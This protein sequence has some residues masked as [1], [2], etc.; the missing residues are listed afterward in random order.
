VSGTLEHDEVDHL[1]ETDF[2]LVQRMALGE[3]DA[4]ARFHSRHGA[5]AFAVARR[6][7]DDLE[8]AEEAVQDA[9][10]AVWRHAAVFRRSAASPRTWLISIVRNRCIDEL[11]RRRGLA[12]L[13]LDDVQPIAIEN[14][15]WPEVW[16]RHC[17]AVVRDALEGL[18]AEQR[19]VIELG[20]YGG[21]SH[22]QIAERLDTPLGTVKKRMRT[23]LTRL[24]TVLDER[25]SRPAE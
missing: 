15:L 18:P 2:S 7:L 20:F 17:G 1:G 4:L 13:S 6:M 24:R 9:F 21:Y 23:G 11:R 19:E 22:A 3:R 14:E 12:H 8:A 16:K 25:F 5:V 10:V